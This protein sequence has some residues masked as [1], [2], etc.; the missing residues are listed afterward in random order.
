MRTQWWAIQLKTASNR[1]RLQK[2]MAMFSM[3][4]CLPAAGLIISGICMLLFAGKGSGTRDF[5]CYMASGRLLAQRTNPYDSDAVLRIEREAGFPA[6]YRSMIMRNPPS[7]LLPTLPLSF[8]GARLGAIL[9][10]WLSLA[11]LVTSVRMLWTMNGRPKGL[12][13]VLSYT[14]APALACLLA[15]QISLLALLGLVLFL[16]LH[17][18]QPFLSGVSLWLCALRPHQFLPFCVVLIL[19]I[20][21]T[22]SYRI[23]LGTIAALGM[24]MA[25]PLL[26]DPLVWTHYL[27]MMA[28]HSGMES[29]FIPSLGVALRLSLSPGSTWLQGVPT[30][31]ACAWAASYYWKHRL[32]WDWMTHGSTLTLVSLLAAPYGW[33]FDQVLAIPALMRGAYC[34]RSSWMLSILALASAAAEIQFLRGPSLHSM[35]YLLT[36]P[37]WL[38]W[39]FFATRP[40]Q[41]QKELPYPNRAPRYP[42]SSTQ[43]VESQ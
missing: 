27:Q 29:E 11:C 41:G 9:W 4:V 43:A 39:Y 21:A 37:A 7:A 22:R 19:W 34:T 36:A 8:V 35:G 26:L 33:F 18:I 15:G 14:F 2:C 20:V 10:A 23:L 5:I 6:E 31:I 40:R 3:A 17:K 1:A 12:I 25:I 16:R 30:V 42:Q 32:D 28:H 38:V 13:I 24:G